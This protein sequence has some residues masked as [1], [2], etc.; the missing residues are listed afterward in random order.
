MKVSL[1]LLD[2]QFILHNREYSRRSETPWEYGTRKEEF[3]AEVAETYEVTYKISDQKNTD[4]NWNN[5]LK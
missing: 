3:A 2:F 4:L 1:I 5:I